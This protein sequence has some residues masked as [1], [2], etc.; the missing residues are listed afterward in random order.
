MPEKLGNYILLN[1]IAKGGM[2]MVYRAVHEP[3]SREVAVKILAPSLAADAE[4]ISRFLREAKTLMD[5]RH[6]N[7]VQVFEANAAQGQYFISMELLG[8]TLSDAMAKL[9]ASKQPMPQAKALLIA[10]QVAAALGFAHEKSLVHR[11]VK[12]SNVLIAHDPGGRTRYVLSDFGVVKDTGATRLT[13][14]EMTIGTPAYMSPEQLLTPGKID[15]RSD[16]YSLGMILYEMLSGITVYDGMT[17]VALM[18][19]IAHEPL[20]PITRFRSDLTGAT[21]AILD[22]LLSKKVETRFQSAKEVIDAIDRALEQKEKRSKLLPVLLTA[23]ATLVCGAGFLAVVLGA[24]GTGDNAAGSG[25]AVPTPTRS[26]ELTAAPTARPVS[27]GPSALP[28]ET[29]QPELRPTSTLIPDSASTPVAPIRPT[30]SSAGATQTAVSPG[31]TPTTA[32][33]TATQPA[34][35]PPA[36]GSTAIP[37]SPPAATATPS[38]ATATPAKATSTPAK[39]TLP[40]PPAPATA[41]PAPTF[42]I[43]VRSTATPVRVNPTPAPIFI[44]AIPPTK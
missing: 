41:T 43:I 12:P 39:A 31:A 21:R 6:P 13:H 17:P 24:Q 15:H 34:G 8:E 42:V 35:T 7:I 30:V 20:A 22:T 11:D 3:T 5:L 40:P 14:T 37:T 1:P 33:P 29:A 27:G 2:A 32:S 9:R 16:L 28:T 4:Y 10:R 25:T 18:Y 19:H 36:P 38:K 26:V 44:T 23:G